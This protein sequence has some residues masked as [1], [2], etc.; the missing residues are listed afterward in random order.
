MKKRNSLIEL[1]R[2]LFAMNVVVGHGLFPIETSHFGPDRISVEFFF[3]LSGFLFCKSLG[4]LKETDTLTAVKTTLISK[5]KPLLVPTVI[6]LI[7]NAFLNVLSDYK[8]KIEIFRY[9]WYIPAMLAIL[10]VY[11]ILRTLIKKDKPF[12]YTVAAVFAVATLLRFSGNETLFFF[13]YI[14]SASAVSLGMLTAKIPK[15]SF[16]RKFISPLLLLPVAIATFLVVYNGLAEDS[17]AYEA[18]LDLLLYPTLIYITFGIEFHFALFDYLGALSFGIYA[19]Q[20][21]ARLVAYIGVPSKW[22]PF[23]II[24]IA[25]VAED[26]IKR[27]IKAKKQKSLSEDVGKADAKA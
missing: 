16:R 6:G 19:F 3:V 23:G 18:L 20:C 15:L 24:I 26:L 4:R 2:F 8:P 7:S 11:A 25:A 1:Y 14:R 10:L 12:W 9:L 21:P 5:L 13:D 22:I 27:I 17:V